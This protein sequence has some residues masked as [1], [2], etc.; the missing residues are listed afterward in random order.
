MKIIKKSK[1]SQK[2]LES[3]V[4][5]E[6]EILKTVKSPFLVPLI[7]SFQTN[8]KLVMIMHYCSRRA[9]SHQLSRKKPLPIPVI[10]LYSCELILALEALHENGFVYRSL[11]FQN[12]FVNHDGHLMLT[13]FEL[14]KKDAQKDLENDFKGSFSYT[15]PEVKNGVPY[16]KEVDWYML[17]LVLYE[18][19]TGDALH[20]ENL[21]IQI[22]NPLLND[23]VCK[24]LKKDHRKR[25]G[26]GSGAAQVK[27]HEF[28]SGV[29]WELVNSKK[30]EMPLPEED[31]ND[32]QIVELSMSDAEIDV[33]KEI[34]QNWSFDNDY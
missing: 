27:A 34:I 31:D 16:G 19:A 1:L 4:K 29:D 8:S 5:T 7:H 18:M 15:V 22:K 17:G 25:L 21:C 30:I 3:M 13:D 28:F 6:L 32:I 11:V 33:T 23:L 10:L 14:A 26:F 12:I 24:L 9:L 20:E 2:N